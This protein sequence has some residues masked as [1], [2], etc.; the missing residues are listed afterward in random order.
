MSM[1]KRGYYMLF[2][3][4]SEVIEE[5]EEAKGAEEKA[6]LKQVLEELKGVQIRAEEQIINSEEEME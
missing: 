1:Y 2:N 6:V 4:I 5:I 3:Q